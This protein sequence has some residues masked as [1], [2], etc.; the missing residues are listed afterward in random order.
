MFLHMLGFCTI[1]ILKQRSKQTLD[2]LEYEC[3]GFN[4]ILPKS[5]P[6]DDKCGF[7]LDGCYVTL[8]CYHINF[9]SSYFYVILH[10]Y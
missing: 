2:V 8:T 3:V 1:N 10:F 6:I 7:Y 5:Y 4:I 9:P